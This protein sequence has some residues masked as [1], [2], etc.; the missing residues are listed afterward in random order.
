MIIIS[1]TYQTVTDA[2]AAI[3]DYSDTGFINTWKEISFRDLVK[4]MREF[5]HAS[6]SGAVNC[7]TW[8][9]SHGEI[10][11]RTGETETR[12]IHFHRDNS[13]KMEKYWR[14]AAAMARC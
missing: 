3:G 7:R 10:D 11:Y 1:E 14:K 8:F 6:S 4:K 12:S 9:S 2:S 5:P 13:P